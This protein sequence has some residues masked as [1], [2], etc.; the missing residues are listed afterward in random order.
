[1]TS[2]LDAGPFAAWLDDMR[3][4]LAGTRDAD[5]PCGTCTACCT[6]A[7]FVPIGP[8]EHA[9]LAAVPP[10]LRF[11]APGLPPGHVLLPYDAQGRCPMLGE[12]GCG[13][14]DAR[15]RACRTYD[16]RVFPATGVTPDDPTKTAVAD[17]ASRW[18]FAYPTAD[19]RALHDRLRAVA[20]DLAGD[21]G[22]LPADRR[23]RNATELAVAAVQVAPG[24]TPGHDDQPLR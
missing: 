7:Q 2:Q 22:A 1:M 14:Y 8:D 9:S 4:A 21:A 10:E 24:V 3:A 18:R 20:T 17:Q 11:P 16:C 19:D 5:V 13:I 23:P 15:P 12:A 6:S